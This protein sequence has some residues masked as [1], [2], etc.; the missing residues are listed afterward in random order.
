M[1][2][3]YYILRLRPCRRPPWMQ[4]A[5]GWLAIET[6]VFL[7]LRLSFWRPSGCILGTWGTIFVIMGSRG[8]P[9][10]HIEGQ[11]SILS[12][13]GSI[14]EVSWDPLWIQLGDFLWFG[15]SKWETVSRS[16]CLVIQGWKGCV[17]S[18]AG[19]A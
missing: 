8:A 12:I 17:N 14:L 3:Y 13:L 6:G 15:M 5:A 16:I 19:C 18:E 1:L 7:Y 10:G 11:I 2:V 4:G 9:N